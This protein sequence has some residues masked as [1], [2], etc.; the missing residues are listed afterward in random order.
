MVRRVWLSRGLPD[1]GID[2]AV[3]AFFAGKLWQGVQEGYGKSI[4]GID[5]D[6]P[7]YKMLAALQENVWHFGAAKNYSMLRDIAG[8]LLGSDGKLRGWRAFREAVAPTVGKYSNGWLQTEYETAVAGGQMASKWTDIQANAASLPV[9]EFDAVLDT[10]TTDLC[11]GLNGT[12]LPIDHPFWATY[13]PPNHFRCR[14][15]VRQLSGGKLTEGGKV[16][17]ADIPDMFK[18]NLAASGL[19][20]PNGHPYYIDNPAG[21][22]ETAKTILYGTKP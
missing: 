3:T 20:F 2:N 11:K 21:L 10:Q 9:L 19:A 6:T 8:Q 1:S 15:T 4:E 16:P 22:K 13:Y 12:R 14:S 17:S 7:D 5:Y 18:T